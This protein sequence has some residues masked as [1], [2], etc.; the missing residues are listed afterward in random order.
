MSSHRGG[1]LRQ[2]EQSWRLDPSPSRV[3]PRSVF[4][5]QDLYRSPTYTFQTYYAPPRGE[6]RAVVFVGHHGAGSCGLTFG[7][8]AAS[9]QAKAR[10]LGYNCVPGVFSYDMRG[11]ARSS[12]LNQATENY[13]MGLDTLTD[14]AVFV[15]N[16]FVRSKFPNGAVDVYLVGHSLGGSVLTSLVHD[17]L[18][19]LEQPEAIK[20]LVVIDIVEETAVRA[21]SSM[22]TYLN[23]IPREFKSVDDAIEWHLTSNLLNNR[24]SAMITV[25]DLIHKSD[26]GT[27]RW[28]CDLR[29]TANYWGGWF[30]GLSQ[31]F[32]SIPNKVSKLLVLA[33][34]DYLDKPLIIG[35]MQGKYQLVIF[36]NNL[37]IQSSTR[38]TLNDSNN[39]GHFIHQDIPDKLA[40]TLLEYVERN[41]PRF[42]NPDNKDQHD[43]L[44]SL[45]KKWGVT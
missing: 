40:I 2:L 9:L 17:N 6:D 1:H 10:L 20:G 28:V 39:V 16:H 42:Y 15:I 29:R 14:D 8:L 24:V 36:H 19:R 18:A 44:M 4:P 22:Q 25:P 5:V 35:Q 13:A 26:S 41:N 3:D 33:N 30:T 23:H 37:N 43:M 38:T 12:S 32:T 11:H 34:N 45:N 27:F 21:L 31:N 7:M